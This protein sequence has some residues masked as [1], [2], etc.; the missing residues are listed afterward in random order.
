MNKSLQETEFTN[1]NIYSYFSIPYGQPTGGAKRFAPP[2]MAG[3]VNDAGTFDRFD[4][5]YLTY[6]TGVLN[7]LCPQ[8]GVSLKESYIEMY[9]KG[10]ENGM[11]S[12]EE[13]R[14]F[15]KHAEELETRAMAGSEDCLTLA[16]HTP[17]VSTVLAL[18]EAY[19]LKKA[20]F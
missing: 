14:I 11:M 12:E 6:L 7:N 5:T 2:E 8:A 20:A 10:A 18:I 1:K 4:G 16:V 17:Y 9:S 3:P 19:A 13:K 15:A